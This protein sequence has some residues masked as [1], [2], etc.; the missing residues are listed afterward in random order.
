MFN[1]GD[2]SGFLEFEISERNVRIFD[3]CYCAT[4][5]LPEADE[6][7][8]DYEKWPEILRG[9]LKGYDKIVNLSPWE[10]EAIPY[11]IYSIQMIFI[12]WLFDNESYKSLAMRNREMLVWIWENRDKAFERIF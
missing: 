5:I 11:V 4:G 2:V 8:G 6:I 9:I 12:A 3:P 1:E 7:E 10:K